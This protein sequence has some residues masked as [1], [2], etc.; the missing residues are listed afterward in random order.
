MAMELM[1]AT[2]FYFRAFHILG[3][4]PYRPIDNE[5]K[6]LA[7]NKDIL[8]HSLAFGQ[9]IVALT[10]SIYCLIP[11]NFLGPQLF[12]GKTEVLIINLCSCCEI[13]RTIFTLIQCIL[14]KRVLY[15]TVSTFRRLE[16][17]FAIHLEYRIMYNRFS[18]KFLMKV[19]CVM[20]SYVQHLVA[21]VL[22][23]MLSDVITPIGVEVKVLQA[24]K[25]ITFLHVIFYIDLLCF[26]LAELNIVI[27][28]DTKNEQCE[29]CILVISKN[30]TKH[31]SIQNK[32]MMYKRVHFR[33]WEISQR[34]NTF[35]GWTMVI[36]LLHGFVDFVHSAYGLFDV[37]QQKWEFFK[38]I[39]EY[40]GKS[41]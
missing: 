30:A 36:V 23:C 13:S 17:F 35:F 24:I 38:I 39:R 10:F 26:Y 15:E 25:A 19:I 28:R 1:S 16:T 40:K 4:S 37:L 27:L 7:S 18:R 31:C 21:F 11:I 34:I 33:L 3:L 41:S 29:N 2:R 14:Y 22:R 6:W 32:V 5:I 8:S 9:A 20:G 12:Y